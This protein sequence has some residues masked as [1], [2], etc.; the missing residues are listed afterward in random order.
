MNAIAP[1]S[2]SAGEVVVPERPAIP[3]I[4]RALA[5]RL[6]DAM[7][8]AYPAVPGQEA[9]LLKTPLALTLAM[10]AEA[11]SVADTVEAILARGVA[12]Q[13]VRAWLLPINAVVRNPQ[14]EDDFELKAATI[15]IACD[16]L[17]EACF[18]METQRAGMKA[19]QFFPSAAD[20]LGVLEPVAEG[21]RRKAAALRA[22]RRAPGPDAEQGG[23][24]RHISEAERQSVAQQ[25]R[26]L[27]AEMRAAEPARKVER[28]KA[29]YLSSRQIAES[30][31][32]DVAKGHGL[33]GAAASLLRLSDAPE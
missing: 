2:R 23:G 1:L 10:A 24:L 26:G 17:P 5:A 29:S 27:A 25:L 33:S 19:W 21:W 30:L 32:G 20:V 6:A 14:G 13:M 15:A 11:G 4:S 22:L 9:G 16:G 7:E 12:P 28:P 18:T 8:P 3:G 31:R